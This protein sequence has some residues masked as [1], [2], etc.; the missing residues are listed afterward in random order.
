MAMIK[1]Y[2]LP[3]VLFFLLILTGYFFLFKKEEPVWFEDLKGEAEFSSSIQ[4][5]LLRYSWAY[6]H[7]EE[8]PSVSPDLKQNSFSF[9][10]VFIRK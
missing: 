7:Q 9:Y 4:E 1:K 8:L 10:S 2:I 3:A 6:F 5:N